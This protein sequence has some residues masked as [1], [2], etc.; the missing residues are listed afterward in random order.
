MFSLIIRNPSLN[1]KVCASDFATKA[2]EHGNAFDISGWRRFVVVQSVFSLSLRRQVASR[3]NVGCENAV[4]Y[5]I[6][7]QGRREVPILIKFGM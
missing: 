7:P 3:P 4:K 6:F 5:G 1:G 2:S